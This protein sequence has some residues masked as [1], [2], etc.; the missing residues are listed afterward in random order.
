[1][2]RRIAHRGYSNEAPENTLAAFEL[3]ADKGFRAVEADVAFTADNYAVIL[4][5]DDV[6][7]TTSGHGELAKM[8]LTEL[9]QLDAGSWKSPEYRLEHVPTFEEFIQV[10]AHRNL[11]PYIELKNPEKLN[12]LQAH[13]L[14]E[15]VRAHG[16][17]HNCTW[18][19][20]K[21]E[22]L[23]RIRRIDPTARLGL[24]CHMIM[25]WTFTSVEVRLR[26]G[27]NYVFIDAEYEKIR[28]SAV[29]GCQDRDIPLELWSTSASGDEMAAES[30]KYVTGFTSNC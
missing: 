8:K 19:S 26:N 28:P 20:F 13:S 27:K 9:L 24:L 6:D 15:T 21:V 14:Y 18:I 5:D 4:H 10:C 2:I 23:E 12:N 29:Y 30:S 16:L 3:A 25:P 11:H 17:V 7:R 22:H 1:M